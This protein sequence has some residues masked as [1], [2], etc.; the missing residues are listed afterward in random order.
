MISR[1]TVL[2]TAFLLVLS[3]SPIE[4]TL[5]AVSYNNFVS[6]DRYYYQSEFTSVAGLEL[7]ASINATALRLGQRLGIAIS[8]YNGLSSPL[9]LSSSDGWKVPGFPVALWPLCYRDLPVE[10]M[11]VKGNYSLGALKAASVN[12]TYLPRF[13]IHCHGPPLNVEYFVFLP[14]SSEAR[15][16]STFCY[17]GCTY[18]LAS[19]FTVNGHWSYPFDYSEAWD[20]WTPA[21]NACTGCVTFNYPEVGPIAQHRFTAGVYTLVVADEWGHTIVFHFAVR[22]L[23]PK[24]SFLSGLLFPLGAPA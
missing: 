13:M 19:N 22:A 11:I 23:T 17:A 20:V 8:L 15:L 1:C 16:A 10:F 5:T 24:T 18:D 14:N 9:N 4:T 2:A 3:A 7:K 21:A 6:G 12:S